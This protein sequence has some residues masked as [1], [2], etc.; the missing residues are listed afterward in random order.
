MWPFSRKKKVPLDAIS[1][2]QTDITEAFGDND[3]L[4]SDEWVATVPLNAM[5]K[6]PESMGLPPVGARADDVYR[7]ASKLSEVR[8]SISIPSD[9]VHCPVCHIANVDLGK[10]RTPLSP[11]RAGVAQVRLG[12]SEPG[13]GVT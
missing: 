2:S 1:Y 13:T 4:G 6:N 11:V 3:R 5:T 8:E 9:G 10:L 7:V 12:L